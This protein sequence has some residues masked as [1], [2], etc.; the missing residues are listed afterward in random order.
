MDTSEFFT[1]NWFAVFALVLWPAVAMY[2]YSTRPIAQATLWTIVGAHL[3][4]PVGPVIKFAMIPALDKYLISSVAALIGCSLV[5]RRSV[6]IW[7]GFG[8]TEVLMLV[9]IFTPF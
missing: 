5:L 9:F 3:L 7:N 2:L 8:L 4:L 6:R 1:P